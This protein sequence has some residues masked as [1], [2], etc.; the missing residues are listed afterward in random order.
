MCIYIYIYTHVYDIYIY[1]YIINKLH[2]TNQRHVKLRN[3]LYKKMRVFVV[4]NTHH[5]FKVFR[6]KYEYILYIYSRIEVLK[7]N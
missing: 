4:Y 6:K 5:R 3:I 1:I 2:T 7:C